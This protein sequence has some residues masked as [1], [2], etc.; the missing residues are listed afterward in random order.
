MIE[1]DQND[2]SSLASSNEGYNNASVIQI[3]LNTEPILDQIHHFLRGTVEYTTMKEDVPVVVVQQISEPKANAH[4]I[5]A[6][7]GWLRGVFSPQSVQGNFS[8]EDYELNEYLYNL[9]MDFA[10][11]L[12]VNLYNYGIPEHEYE[13]IIDMILTI[14]KP[15]LTRTLDDGERK[16]YSTTMKHS[17]SATQTTNKGGNGFRLPG[18]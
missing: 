14:V 9:R 5:H 13:G 3:R 12:M 2:L 18:M 17:E 7:M 10:E 11:Y 15:F 1:T 4:G 6:I 8:K 16:S